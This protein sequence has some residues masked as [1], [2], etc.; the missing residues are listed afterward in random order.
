MCTAVYYQESRDYLVTSRNLPSVSKYQV[1]SPLD[2]PS[3]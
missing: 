2:E 3:I 1:W